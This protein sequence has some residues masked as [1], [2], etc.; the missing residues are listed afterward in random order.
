MSLFLYAETVQRITDMP[1]L[2]LG[3]IVQNKKPRISGV[4]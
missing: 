1:E 2:A 4:L 3:T